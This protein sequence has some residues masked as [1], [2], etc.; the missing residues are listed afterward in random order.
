MAPGSKSS[1]SK[2]KPNN[3]SVVVHR[4][5]YSFKPSLA[6]TYKSRL[7]PSSLLSSFST[8]VYSPVP[9]SA[10]SRSSAGTLPKPACATFRSLG[11]TASFL[12]RPCALH[13]TRFLSL[14]LPSARALFIPAILVLSPR[15]QRTLLPLLN[16][17]MPSFLSLTLLRFS[18]PVSLLLLLLVPLLLPRPIHFISS[19]RSWSRF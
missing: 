4:H 16:L 13:L 14:S 15:L 12:L 18:L 1:L 17:S 11:P 8:R 6:F 9:D 10:P 7:L 5:V 2:S 19:P 3:I